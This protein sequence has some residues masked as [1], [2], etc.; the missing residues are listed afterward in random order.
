MLGVVVYCF[1]GKYVCTN[2]LILQIELNWLSSHRGFDDTSFDDISGIGI[3]EALL[4]VLS[5]YVNKDATVLLCMLYFLRLLFW[6]VSC[7]TFFRPIPD[8]YAKTPC[9]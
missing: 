6:V 4:N 3:P 9:Y 7:F 1:I 5:S 8:F 2:Y